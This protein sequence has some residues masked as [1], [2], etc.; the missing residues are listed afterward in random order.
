MCEFPPYCTSE[1]STGETGGVH[2]ESACECCM[3]ELVSKVE[4][5]CPVEISD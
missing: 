3:T 4:E 5:E 1:L 2:L